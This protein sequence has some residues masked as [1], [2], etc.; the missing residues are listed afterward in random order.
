MIPRSGRF[1]LLVLPALFLHPEFAGAL[2]LDEAFRLA[3][4]K[5]ENIAIRREDVD[6]ARE[7]I[8]LARAAVLPSLT[9]SVTQSRNRVSGSGGFATFRNNR[10]SRIDIDQ[11]L[12]GGGKEWATL[13]GAAIQEEVARKELQQ[14]QQ[15]ILFEAALEFFSLL[16]A[17]ENLSIARRAFDLARDQLALAAARKE[18]GAATRTEV[19]RSEVSVATARRD[20]VRAENS[21]GVY[22]ARLGHVIGQTVA[23]AVTAPADPQP[24]A[25]SSQLESLTRRALDTRPDYH[26]T[27][28]NLKVAEEGVKAARAAYRPTANLTGNYSRTEN[29]TSFR[30]NDNWQ[31]QAKVEYD[32]FDGLGRDANYE[33]SRIVLRQA[34]LGQMRMARQIELEVHESI[35]DIE[36][37]RAILRATAAEVAAGRENYERVI[38]QF[39][40][41]LSTAVDVADAHTAMI[42]AE[43]E[44]AGARTDLDLAGKKL[45]LAIGSMGLSHLNHS[46]EVSR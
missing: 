12:Y 35:L 7:N 36:A 8:R 13:R 24:E 28:L 30:D 25:D 3:L 46:P 33:Q 23:E 38:A 20:L 40:E 15:A 44:Q 18:A 4:K 11:P 19:I 26:V 22:R 34:A 21:V 9:A 43:V 2:T 41:G 10:E 31:V 5:N 6:A 27:R 29:V 14:I 37:L 17:Q 42:A 1:T 45:E 32:I 16:R 39:R